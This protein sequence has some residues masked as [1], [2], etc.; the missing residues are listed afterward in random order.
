MDERV[1]FGYL[2][3]EVEEG[4]FQETSFGI[5]KLASASKPEVPQSFGTDK[6]AKLAMLVYQSNYQGLTKQAN[7]LLYSPEH[8]DSYESILQGV[9]ASSFWEPLGMTKSALSYLGSLEQIGVD[10]DELDKLANHLLGDSVETDSVIGAVMEKRAGDTRSMG[11][12]RNELTKVA[13]RGLL[14]LLRRPKPSI[15]TSPKE[16]LGRGAIGAGRTMK[17][18]AVRLGEKAEKGIKKI[19]PGKPRK[20]ERAGKA[21]QEFGAKS[22]VTAPFRRAATAVRGA[23]RKVR[24]K[25]HAKAQEA[26]HRGIRKL[27]AEREGL[28]KQ[29]SGSSAGQAEQIGTKIQAVN[30]KIQAQVQRARKSSAKRRALQEEAGIRRTKASRDAAARETAKKTERAAEAPKGKEAP[31]E[32]PKGGGGRTFSDIEI[33]MFRRYERRGGPKPP[34]YD[35]W[36]RSGNPKAGERGAPKTQTGGGASGGP[37]A[38]PKAEPKTKPK[39]KFEEAP[40]PKERYQEAPPQNVERNFARKAQEEPSTFGE[41]YSKWKD[42]GWKALSDA[43]K[44]KVYLGAGG[45]FVAQRA[46]MDKPII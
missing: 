39:E 1:A 27:Q 17:Q 33:G 37:A 3:R 22:V 45:A 15:P 41:I 10:E 29:L 16:M 30:R 8:L 23:A 7:K 20:F 5:A 11:E 6:H 43:E 14:R 21:I 2:I 24:G 34:G 4:F 31:K 42:G 28:R 18:E 40:R 32:A 13:V 9:A 19:T 44:R 35:E 38:A 26:R 12:I 25:F 36:K 46:L